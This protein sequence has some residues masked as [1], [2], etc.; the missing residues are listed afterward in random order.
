MTD[1]RD[2]IDRYLDDL[3]TRLRGSSTDVRRILAETEQHLR[4]AAHAEEQRGLDPMAAQQHA[5]QRFGATRKV[6]REFKRLPGWLPPFPTLA[7]LAEKLAFLAAVG[8]I[9][10]GISG[11]VSAIFG[12]AFGKSFVAGDAPGVTYTKA[13]CVDYLEYHPEA[14]T[15]AKAAVAH[16]FDEDV[17]YRVDAGIL[18]VIALAVFGLIRRFNRR[19]YGDARFLPDGFTGAIGAALFGLAA[20]GLLVLG[21]GS[22]VMGTSG[23][24]G[25]NL[26]G[27]IVALFVF[28]AFLVTLLRTLR[29]RA[30]TADVDG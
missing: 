19:R 29:E 20:L 25:A 3:L 2:P 14:G 16:H 8:L 24:S 7:Q 21:L 27:G 15:C 4:E 11:G 26:S 22:L 5:I 28:V 17:G 6:A 30:E 12:A 10:I 1:D 13:R 23:G 9:A 18:G